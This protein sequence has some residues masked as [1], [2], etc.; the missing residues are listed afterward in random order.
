MD[1][2]CTTVEWAMSVK[3]EAVHVVEAAVTSYGWTVL[4]RDAEAA[5]VDV[6]V[7]GSH[8]EAVA[9]HVAVEVATM[10]AKA[11]VTVED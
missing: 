9:V 5:A 7:V 2:G 6:E 4:V 3:E 10:V 8:D 11:M 1:T